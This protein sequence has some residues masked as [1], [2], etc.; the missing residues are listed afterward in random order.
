ML[1]RLATVCQGGRC[2]AED[3]VGLKSHILLWKDKPLV[4]SS[5]DKVCVIYIIF[6]AS[7]KTLLMLHNKSPKYPSF[8]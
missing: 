3:Q 1:L 7:L 2:L 4:C 5:E 8:S 6:Y